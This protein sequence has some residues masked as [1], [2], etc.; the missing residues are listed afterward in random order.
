MSFT[1]TDEAIVTLAKDGETIEYTS[2]KE[3]DEDGAYTLTFENFDGYKKTYTFTIDKVAPEA[4]INDANNGETVN[5]DISITFTEENLTA[6]LYKDGE[7]VGEYIS[8]T[9][10]KA[11]GAYKIIVKDRANN[12]T[13]LE[14][15]IDK[16]APAVILEG[17]ENGGSTNGY[18]IIPEISET[19]DYTLTKNGKA[20][21]YTLGDKITA[22][23]IYK[24][25]ATDAYGNSET[26]NFVIEM[27]TEDTETDP[28]A[29]TETENPAETVT[30]TPTET[31]TGTDTEQPTQPEIPPVTDSET[32]SGD[33]TETDTNT[34]TKSD[35]GTE[36]AAPSDDGNSDTDD[37]ANAGAIVGI[38]LAVLGTGGGGLAAFFLIRKK[39]KERI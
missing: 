31:E 19:F 34:G 1:W 33:V 7:F 5:K 17:V 36:T 32:E 14:F 28:P 3:L 6:E 12:S 9:L 10:V 16:T 29:E 37:G 39:K 11:D 35:S 2:G 30:E 20:V 8:G 18:V 15:G 22:P 21:D 38:S 26:Y 4:T 24:F 25:I 13:E 27:V 23:G